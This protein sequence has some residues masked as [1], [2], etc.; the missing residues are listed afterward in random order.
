VLG[1]DEL[2]PEVERFFAGGDTTVR[3]Y[4]EDRLATEIIEAGVPPLGGASQL[5]VLP[6]GGNI[7]ALT[8]IDAQ[9]RLT[10]L[11]GTSLPLASGLF[12]DA[13]IVRNVW[14][15]FDVDA[16]RPAVGVSLF[17]IV[18]P[19][20]SFALDYAV[21]IFPQLGDDPLGRLHISVALRN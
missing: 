13:G 2:L 4:E 6:A 21:P 1:D 9:I 10:T 20:G 8:S 17:R 12:V 18:T 11:P 14:R 5:R 3:G 19:V 7:R 16:I 15:P